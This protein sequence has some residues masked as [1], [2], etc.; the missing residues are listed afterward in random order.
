MDSLLNLGF[1]FV[2]L[3]PYGTAQVNP[4]AIP[5]VVQTARVAADQVGYQQRMLADVNRARAERG[6][7][8]ISMQGN[9]IYVQQQETQNAD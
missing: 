6:L 8:P 9:T 2:H 3:F 4:F 1:A 7:A 5:Q